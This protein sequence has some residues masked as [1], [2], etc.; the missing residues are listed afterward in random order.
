LALGAIPSAVAGA[1]VFPVESAGSG[2][3]I[4]AVYAAIAK[5]L[6]AKTA[7][8]YFPAGSYALTKRIE[9]ELPAGASI[10][11]RG[12]GAGLSRI[13]W[14]CPEGGFAIRFEP[15]GSGGIVVEGLS[16]G[17]SHPSGGTAIRIAST[18]GTSPSPKKLIRDVAIA[19]G[20]TVGVDCE[21]CTFTSVDGVDFRGAGAAS[22]AAIRFSGEHDPVD[23]Y[24]SRLR[25]T[26]AKTG[27]EVTGS[28]EGVYVEQCTMLAVER[29]VHWHTPRGEP[30]LSLSGSHVAASR[31]CVLGHN[32]IQP[33]ISGNLFYQSGASDAGWTAIKLSAD[34]PSIYDLIQVCDNTIHGFPTFP[35]SRT[36]ITIANRDG[37]LVRGN[38]IHGCETGVLIDEKSSNFKVLDNLVRGSKGGVDVVDRGGGKGNFV[39]RV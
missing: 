36:G 28:C 34:Q 22:D 37:G 10:A 9:I 11:I 12:D 7:V 35:G 38:I 18:G 32:L 20:W 31:E 21:N 13:D 30:L 2:D 33:I 15:A 25:V 4:A 1:S 3:A 19:G 24:V 27:I 23:N 14:N 39:R 5:C 17:T 29:G 8:L 26:S 6:V 16:L